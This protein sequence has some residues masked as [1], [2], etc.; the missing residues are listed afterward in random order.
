MEMEQKYNNYQN[1]EFTKQR[2]L[3]NLKILEQI[4][5]W[6]DKFPDMRFMQIL[7]NIGIIPKSNEDLWYEEPQDTLKRINR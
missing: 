5:N 3:S 7:Y 6:V 2:H 1:P 4:H